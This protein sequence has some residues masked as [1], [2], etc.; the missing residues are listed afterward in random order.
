MKKLLLL[1][2]VAA[3]LVACG[4]SDGSAGAAATGTQQ[5]IT[6]AA[7]TFTSNVT[8]VVGTSSDSVEPAAL[9]AS[10]AGGPE[11]AEPSPVS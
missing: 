10:A 2:P 9:D 4:G 5:A 8:A 11:D 1:I 3:L 7:D 6:P